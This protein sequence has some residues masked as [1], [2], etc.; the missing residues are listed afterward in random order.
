MSMSMWML[1]CAQFDYNWSYWIWTHPCTNS[2]LPYCLQPIGSF[3]MLMTEFARKSVAVWILCVLLASSYRIQAVVVG[4]NCDHWITGGA[5]ICWL[6]FLP[7][8]RQSEERHNDA[9]TDFH[10]TSE[11]LPSSEHPSASSCFL[12]IHHQHS[13]FLSHT[14][15]RP[16]LP[17][18]L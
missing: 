11:L 9:G 2:K 16:L 8:S 10:A 3:Q 14:H 6:G 13:F 12:T 1:Q 7:C 15:L 18:G 5:W 17:G 4:L